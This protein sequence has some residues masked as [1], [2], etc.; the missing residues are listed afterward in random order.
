MRGDWV[1][2]RQLGTASPGCRAEALEP[3]RLLAGVT[4]YV[5][6][7]GDDANAGT[8]ADSAWRTPFRV[9]QVDLEPGDRVLF[10][11]GQTFN[12]AVLLGPEDAGAA[13]APV[14]VGSYGGGRAT[15]RTESVGLYAYAVGAFRVQDVNFVG[16]GRT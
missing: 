3:R 11:G 16:A 7:S 5:N 6:N 4:Y 8:S 10:R 9:N 1:K 12:G 13:A 15:I 14:T 2:P